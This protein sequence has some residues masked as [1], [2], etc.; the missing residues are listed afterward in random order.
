MAEV[1]IQGILCAFRELGKSVVTED[2][3]LIDQEEILYSDLPRDEQ[4]FRRTEHPFSDDELV[5][6]ATR[7]LVYAGLSPIQKQWI[8]RENKRF[9]EGIYAYIDGEL[10]FIPGAYYCYVNYWTLEHGEK[11]EYRED[12][13][14]F[15]LFHEYLRLE[16]I[17]LALTRLKGRRQGATSIGM[18]FMWFIAGRNAHKLCG[19]TSFS[20]SASQDNFQRMFMY[21]FK[22]LLPC[23]Q[24]DFD[25]DSEN[26]IRFVK[27]VE[28][29]KKGILAVKREGLNS[30]CDYKSNVINSYDSLRQSYNV[31]DEAGKRNKVNIN[32]YYSRLYKTF[33]VGVNKVGFGYLPTTVGA[34]KEGGEN[35]KLFYE[36]SNQHKI[37]K[38]TGL[39]VGLNTPT[40]CVRYFVPATHCYAGCIDK[41]GR[42]II[43]DPTEPVMG[44]DGNWITEGSKTII[45]RERAK[46]EGEQLMEH[47]RDYPLDEYDAFA[48]ET[49]TC[50]F[51][52]ENF[53]ARIEYLENHPEEAF[54]RQGRLYEEYDKEQKKIIVKWA[55]DPKGEF[56]VKEFPD[57]DNCYLDRN[58][59]LEPLNSIMYSGGAD[60]YKNI[61]AEK[62][63]DGAICVTKKSCIIDGV[64]TGLLPVLFFVGRPKLI[65]Q[66]NRAMFLVCLYYGCKINIEIDAGTWFYEDFLEW[67][68]L[69]FLEWSPAVDLTKPNFKI[70]PGTQSGNPFE[71]AKQLEVAKLFY[72]GNSL[73]SYNGNVHR[74]TFLPQ[75]KEGLRYNHSERTPF[76]L[77]VCFMMSL[78]PLLGRPRPRGGERPSSKPKHILPQRKIKLPS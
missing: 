53:I 24:A 8:D 57:Q 45:L 20:D 49:G 61:F 47:R 69:Q 7:E 62:G 15:F 66:F 74:C 13:R 55:D 12:D 2:G 25:S 44:N 23:F 46:L 77:T 52:E 30:Y 76:H 9:S 1:L 64:E 19:T 26:F 4:Y 65:K 16:T 42:S 14:V 68:A 56:W 3:E 5:A 72:D 51:N 34:K 6:I 58:G 27:P 60:T 29:K 54:W 33:L 48:F 39:P 28:K 31:P 21:G 73:T 22:A 67:D 63:S 75:L 40:R 71:L 11:P 38:E 59:T 17:V 70:L 43:E 50:E 36:N 10:T 32:S 37:D 35:Y 41:F 18:F 78:L